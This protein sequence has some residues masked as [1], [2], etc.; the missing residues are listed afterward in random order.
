MTADL[1]HVPEAPTLPGPVRAGKG[2]D[3]ADLYKGPVAEPAEPGAVALDEKLRQAYF[4]IV[5]K[6][7]ISPHYDIEYHDG[8]SPTF[9]FGD[10]KTPVS[11]PSGQ[12]YSSFVLLPL[13]TF[14]TRRRCLF[15]GGPGRGKT[16]SAVLM[17]V[18]AGYS[19]K[20][21]RRS[22]QHGHPQMTVADLLGSPLPA[23]LLSARSVDE[24]RIGWRAWLS[25]RVRI[26]DEYNRIPTRTQSALLTVL[27]DGYAELFDQIYECPDGAWFLT[28]ND[29]AGGGTY[30]VIEAL[31][32]RIDVV[33]QA[34]SF[35]NRFLGDL[36]DRIERQY[37]PEDV[38][39]AQLVFTPD[40][41]DRMHAAI[42]A[43]EVPEPV[44]RRLEH[45]ASH[46]EFF[47]PAA[48]QLEY[49]T[50]D[51]A[52]LAGVDLHLLATGE[53][54]RDRVA[55]L[56]TQTRNGLSVRSLQTLLVYAKALAFFRAQAAVSLADLR[57]VLPFAL[58]DKL[59]PDL[60]APFFDS[61]AQQPLRVDRVGWI[62]RLFDL[63][64]ADYDRLDLDHADPVADLLREFN[65]GLRDVGEA[66]A[67]TRLERIERL[68]A[69]WSQ[70]RKLH[71]TV[72]DDIL[73]L[74]YLHQ[75]YTNYLAW[76]RW[77]G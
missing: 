26:V 23:D 47:E 58:H 42:L 60:D 63:A 61:P 52:R 73:V 55:D 31:K 36:V 38:V 70:G 25:M 48:V 45:F 3:I 5:N 33:V 1:G 71:G 56:G 57:Q 37:R 32:D 27:G 49:M 9:A 30:P 2:F 13:L 11:L 14:A 75:R 17:G 16:A 68:L 62:R 39:P 44:R 64:T 19:V 46:F 15:V 41:L 4:W 76:L 40:E 77:Q 28:A 69:E 7:I 59:V 51:T 20:D 66:T 72:Y 74:K 24:I 54:G 53:T 29:D 50:K 65:S 67:R 43:V 12:S 34:L 21:V 18:L 35:N 22:M 8:P 6:A 10:A